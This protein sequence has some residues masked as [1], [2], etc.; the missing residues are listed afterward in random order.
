MQNNIIYITA[1]G[2]QLALSHD[3]G[4]LQ[5]QN[6]WIKSGWVMGHEPLTG[7]VQDLGNNISGDD[8]GFVNLPEQQFELILDS[9]CIDMGSLP[10][11][12]VENEYIPHQQFRPRFIINEIDI[13]A[14]ESR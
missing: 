10:Q 4:I 3:A 9:P 8:P 2:E 12:P 5:M 1:P 14:Y 7:S 13:G 11:Y 6:N